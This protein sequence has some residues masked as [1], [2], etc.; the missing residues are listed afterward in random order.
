MKLLFAF[1]LE[2]CE[3]MRL[4]VNNGKCSVTGPVKPASAAQKG[5]LSL[6]LDRWRFPIRHRKKLETKALVAWKTSQWLRP[7]QR[8]VT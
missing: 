7:Y 3:H 1:Y 8:A 5:R 2:W 6:A 4:S